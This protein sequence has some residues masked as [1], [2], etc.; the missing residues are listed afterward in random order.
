MNEGT[1]AIDVTVPSAWPP[2]APFRLFEGVAEGATL[3]VNARPAGTL[4][5]QVKVG[6]NEM[7]YET[8]RLLLPDFAFLKLAFAWGKTDGIGC[9]INGMLLTESTDEFIKLDAKS[10]PPAGFR[11]QRAFHVPETCSDIERSFLRFLL[12]LQTRV[13]VKD[14]FNL[15]EVSAI[16]RR[17]L[18]DARPILHLVNREHRQQLRFPFAS[19]RQVKDTGEGPVFQFMNLCPDFADPT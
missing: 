1:L 5:F 7:S 10:H 8:P 13:L 19:E 11:S 12:D 2:L 15:L 16:L 4:H 18:L 14:R 9:A 6:N 17:L 3:E